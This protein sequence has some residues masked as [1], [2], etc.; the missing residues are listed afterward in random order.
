MLLLIWIVL[1]LLAASVLLL[2]FELRRYYIKRRYSGTRLVSCPEDQRPGAVSIDVRHAMA[3]AIDGSPN[4]RVSD[5]SRWPERSQCNRACLSHV[6][7]GDLTW[8]A[9]GR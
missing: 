3:T 4:L 2:P 9:I 5:C 1:C 6:S 7:Q 8:R